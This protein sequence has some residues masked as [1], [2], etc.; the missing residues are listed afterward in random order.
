M[1][2]MISQLY[3]T[4]ADSATFRLAGALVASAFAYQWGAVTKQ[5]ASA[6]LR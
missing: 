1:I 6:W 3:V 2:S 5:Y 4:A